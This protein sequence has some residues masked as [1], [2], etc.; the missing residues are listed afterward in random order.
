VLENKQFE[1]AV[2]DSNGIKDNRNNSTINDED[3]DNELDFDSMLEVNKKNAK[4]ELIES[5]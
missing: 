1:E 4:Q 2:A 5:E 3:K